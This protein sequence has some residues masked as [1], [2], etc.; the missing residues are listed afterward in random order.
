[1][2]KNILIIAFL[3]I[4]ILAIVF[5]FYTKSKDNL[6]PSNK[7][8]ITASFYPQFFLTQQIV[9]D[10][11]E[12]IN[13]TP[14][15]AEPHEYEP[16]T[17]EMIKIKNSK[18]LIL[19]GSKFEPWAEKIKDT[20]KETKIISLSENLANQTTK[21]GEENIKDPHIW[22]SPAL[23]KEE[24]KLIYNEI[25]KI[26]PEN[27]VFYQENLQ[28][29]ENNLDLLNNKFKDGLKNCAKKDFITSHSAFGYLA[30]AYNLNQ[31]AISGL[32]PDEE[33]SPKKLA[34]VANFVRQNNIK[35]I[36]FESLV[37][38]KLSETLALET[39]TQTLILN[40]LEG[41][42]E[43]EINQGKNY[44]TEMENNLT[45]LKIALECK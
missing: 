34:E 19:N 29:L 31:V 24:A 42:S 32:S 12:V 10:K 6:L 35:Y 13:I 30:S 18:L 8:S 40:P 37:S 43:E 14:A 22:L 7:I 4:A 41:I 3:F 45:N 2:K 26:D 39:G 36:F 28:T 21:E 23:V 38:P 16:T 1:M 5:L 15:G 33:P 17:R 20:F 27:L 9:K 25:I 44:F 11:I